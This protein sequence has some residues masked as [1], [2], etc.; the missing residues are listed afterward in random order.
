MTI[1]RRWYL[2]S[3]HGFLDPCSVLS[4]A[5]PMIR[6]RPRETS[7]NFVEQ[8]ASNALSEPTTT[9]VGLTGWFRLYG[10]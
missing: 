1:P 5:S 8:I 9:M 3:S 6:A 7:L 10:A 4:Q 2:V